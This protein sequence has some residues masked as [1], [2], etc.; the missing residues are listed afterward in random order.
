MNAFGAFCLLVATGAVGCTGTITDSARTDRT[1]WTPEP[2]SQPSN[3]TPSPSSSN[4]SGEVPV[5]TPPAGVQLPASCLSGAKAGPSPLRRL[6]NREY[7]RTVT[8][9]LQLPTAPAVAFPPEARTM[10]FDNF[11]L[12][13]T[14]SPELVEQ[15]EKVAN[16]LALAAAKDLPALLRCDLAQQGE[17]ACAKSFIAEFGRRA[18]RRPLAQAEQDRLFAFWQTERTGGLSVAF[19]ALVAA[20][21]QSPSFLY[22]AE[23][24]VS[25]DPGAVVKLTPFEVATRLS[26]M[27]W[28]TM[29]Q[30]A[31][32]AAAETGK[33]NTSAE[34]AAQAEAMLA[35]PRA[36]QSTARFFDQWLT[37]DRVLA[38]D[39]D[40]SVFPLF[41]PELRALWRQETEL[42]LEELVSGR[43]G[44]WE[45][46]FQ[47][48]YTFANAELAQF[49]G[50]PNVSGTDFR[51]VQLDTSKRLGFLTQASMLAVHSKENQTS[52]I[53][54]GLFIREHLLCEQMP[55][56]PNNLVIEVPQVTP[57]STTRERF[58][59]HTSVPSC[60]SCHLLIDPPGHGLENYDAVGLWRDTDQGRP[61]DSSGN[62]IGSADVDGPF[63]GAVELG[64]RLA[65][66]EQAKACVATQWFRYAQARG[67]TSDDAC[68]L[69]LMKDEF[70]R[71]AWDFKK[72][73]VAITHTPAFL[74]RTVQ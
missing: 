29:P 33:L 9:L 71:G 27:L 20:V 59:L 25:G 26:Y 70:R 24:G 48:D 42:F 52:P 11:A 12:V 61:I 31:L 17:E 21:L 73:I 60:A 69:D 23:V 1:G 7:A 16:E 56:P 10:G 13:Q 41:K 28:G 72:L 22:K 64:T 39:K 14:P 8:D 47:A 18:Y 30:D 45:N 53:D 37:L 67:E 36:K 63:R 15:Y 57:G 65:G 43:S 44:G 4:P 55:Q 46:F 5:V 74:N 2:T 32:L 38:L 66:S 3:P 35:D 40:V 51:R 49:Y 34:V 68:T 50:I 58:A 54:R 6:T 62:I 19:E